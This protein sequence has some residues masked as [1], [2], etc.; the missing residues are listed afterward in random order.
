[1][2]RSHSRTPGPLV[3]ESRSVTRADVARLAGVSSAVVSYVV[4]DGPRPV[5]AAT[6]QRVR[7]AMVLLGY[8]P[9]A[10]ARALRTGTTDTVGLVLGDSRNPFF[11]EYT[12]ELVK[13]A[14]ARGKHVLIGDA[15]QYGQGDP[16][17]LVEALVARQVD[18]LLFAAP[19]RGSMH[20]LTAAADVP[21][22]LVDAPGPLAGV[23][24]VGSAARAGAEEVTA[25]L[26]GHGRRHVAL[27]IGREG[28]GDPDPREAGWLSAHVESGVR[29]GPVLRTPFTREGGYAG[30]VQLLQGTQPV[31]AIFASNDLQAIG[32]LRALNEHARAVPGDIA[33]VS[34]DGTVEAEFAW[35][36]LTV[37]RQNVQ[38]MA[39]AALDLLTDPPAEGGR[40][41]E[42]PTQLIIRASCGCPITTTRAS[43][44]NY[45]S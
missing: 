21:F 12:S 26:L 33:L 35:P 18:G 16:A 30:T 25:H 7:E 36:P 19:H 38:A 31:D 43:A 22:V 6:A 23:C 34:Y 32:A 39:G 14:A 4:N 13:A 41:I 8:R 29:P 44:P 5:A 2:T 17:A 37:V 15:H 3:R 45:E 1:M 24:S 10:S 28:F 20:V 40:H 9:N 27:L 11:T 42:I